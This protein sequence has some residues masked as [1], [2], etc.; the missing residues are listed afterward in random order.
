MYY[1]VV[2]ALMY[3]FPLLSIAIEV[4]AGRSARGVRAIG[5][6]CD[7]QWQIDCSVTRPRRPCRP[8]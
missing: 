1:V 4:N 2:A 5:K 7:G 3:V 6:A 8:V